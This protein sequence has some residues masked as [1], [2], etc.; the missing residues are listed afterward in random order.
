MSQATPLNI[1]LADDDEDDRM[2]FASALKRI[3]IP[4]HLTTVE[5]GE[6]LIAHLSGKNPTDVLFLDMNMPRKNGMECLLEIKANEQTKDIPIIIY[7]TS[8]NESIADIFYQK[9]AHYYLQKSDFSAL[10]QH[11]RQIL[12]LMT[13]KDF[14]RKT[15]NKFIFQLHE[16]S[17]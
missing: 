14:D 12:T 6:K 1:L 15:R 5:D 2:F 10:I 9:G 17:N 7:S 3:S 4:T 16:N 13:K 8:L 11:L